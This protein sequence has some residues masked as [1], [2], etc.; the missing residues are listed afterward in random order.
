M[1]QGGGAGDPLG[2]LPPFLPQL[3]L[4]SFL[5][6]HRNLSPTSLGTEDGLQGFYAEG[7]ELEQAVVR[8]GVTPGRAQRSGV[9]ALA[10]SFMHMHPLTY[11]RR[12]VHCPDS[13]V[14]WELQRF[15]TV[16]GCRA[17]TVLLSRAA[18]WHRL[19]PAPSLGGFS[20]GQGAA[21]ARGTEPAC[22]ERSL[23]LP[24]GLRREESL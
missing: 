1:W 22:A 11:T 20:A 24:T 21:A 7:S 5:G 18:G 2:N 8:G 23:L 16:A 15:W 14:F 17:D 9:S 12:P 3:P 13:H 4:A 6:V 19:G 10:H